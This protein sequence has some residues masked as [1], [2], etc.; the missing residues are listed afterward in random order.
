MVPR[1]VGC[2]DPGPGAPGT[3]FSTRR[4]PLADIAGQSDLVLTSRTSM[5]RSVANVAFDSFIFG[6]EVLRT[7]P[8]EG[9]VRGGLERGTRFD[10]ITL[11]VGS[12]PWNAADVPWI[13]V[14]SKRG[15]N[16]LELD[17]LAD[18]SSD[19]TGS[20]VVGHARFDEVFDLDADDDA[21][22]LV[23]SVLTDELCEWAVDADER[24]GPLTV[25]F[26]GPEDGSGEHGT[27]VF[28]EREVRDDDAF[29]ETRAITIDLVT[30]LL[31]ATTD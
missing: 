14:Q 15:G 12:M 18:A 17:P 6:P 20:N 24:Y 4:T 25:V 19:N 2:V 23:R 13:A 11:A 8:G 3:G 21:M 10:G 1:I 22:D 16:H 29:V 7:E 27:T 30:G 5:E 31:R 28:V 26:D 9:D